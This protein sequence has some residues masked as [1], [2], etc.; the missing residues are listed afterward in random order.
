MNAVLGRREVY[1]CQQTGIILKSIDYNP[2]GEPFHESTC[3]E[4]KVNVEVPDS[5]FQL[6]LPPGVHY[7]PMTE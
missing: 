6:E 4:L 1:Y 3:S 2:A 5:R 7:D